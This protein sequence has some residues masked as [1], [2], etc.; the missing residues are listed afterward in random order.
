MGLQ[1]MCGSLTLNFK[2]PE[3]CKYCYILTPAAVVILVGLYKYISWRNRV[4]VKDKVVMITGASS[5]IG[6]AC[7]VEFYKAGAK[8]ILAS[9]TESNLNQVRDELQKSGPGHV[10]FVQTIDMGDYTSIRQATKNVLQKYGHVDILINNA[11]QGFRGAVIQT[12]ISVHEN[13]MKVNYFGQIVLTQ[14]LLPGMISNGRGDIVVVSSVQG[15]V[16][17]PYRAAYGASK[18]ALECYFDILRA[19]HVDDNINV[20]ICSPGYVKTPLAFKALNADGTLHGKD[21]ADLQRG[22]SPDYIGSSIL[23]GVQYRTKHMVLAPL[24]HRLASYSSKMF[25]NLAAMV[26]SVK[27]RS[28]KFRPKKEQ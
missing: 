5:G 6:K 16:Y 21:D 28:D 11:G 8:V 3:D 4:V 26:M 25:W 23:A 2:M 22:V 27:A 7:A 1:H 24:H 9:R 15:K 10:P 14:E 12:D 20:C 18:H 13:M 19:E 17:V